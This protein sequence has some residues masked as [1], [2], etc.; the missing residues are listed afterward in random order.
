MKENRDPV[1]G[2]YLPDFDNR[3]TPNYNGDILIY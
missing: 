1:K 3:L 2:D